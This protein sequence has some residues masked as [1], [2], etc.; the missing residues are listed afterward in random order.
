MNKT[1]KVF[2]YEFITLV[3]RRSFLLM[4]ILVPLIP[5]LLLGGLRLLNRG[6]D[7]SLQ[8]I[9]AQ[10]M[11]NPLPY[12]VVDLGGLIKSYPD[13][14]VNGELVPVADEAS[15]REQTA[16]GKLEGFYVISADYLE[17]GKILLVKPQVS[18]VTE[19]AQSRTLSNLINYHL[20]G[21]D[22]ELYLKYSNPA[23]VVYE[24]LN[25]AIADTRD[26]NNM[27]SYFLPYGVAMFLY[28]FILITASLMLIAVTKDKENRVMEILVSSVKP[29]QLFT[30][31]I[32]ALGLVGLLQM[33]VWFGTAVLVM[34]L[35]GTTLNIPANLQIPGLAIAM[36][37]PYFV[38]GFLIYGS[39]MAGLG[40]LVPNL[41]EAN[42]SSFVILMPMIFTIMA[43]A[44]LIENPEG[45]M[46]LF[47]SLFPLTSSVGM[48]TRLT[49]GNVPPW[50]LALSLAILLGT[51]VIIVRGVANLFH[52]QT[53]LTGQK[54]K[55]G[56][57]VRTILRG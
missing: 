45:G 17:S 50:Q 18:L 29:I 44:Q 2:K 9:F 35:N 32:A 36:V 22:Q 51:V 1:A 52:A 19:V 48:M 37:V 8:E 33:V 14:I 30:G 47:L 23:T 5:T 26:T 34:R 4:L 20:L 16:A 57:F 31:K 11:S 25:V 46:A 28:M 15:A 13:W 27:Y 12:G 49:I 54:F 24:P 41:K 43:N 7:K 53:L 55:F 6:E 3:S 38:L 56:T 39:L 40:A 10:E 42:Q 21:S